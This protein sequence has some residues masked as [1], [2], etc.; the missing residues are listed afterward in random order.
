M[1]LF[2]LWTFVVALAVFAFT[3]TL[4]GLLKR[5]GDLTFNEWHHAYLGI[6]LFAVGLL[7]RM[8]AGHAGGWSLGTQIAG[9][10]L[11]FDDAEEHLVQLVTGQITYQSPAHALFYALFGALGIV[12][13]ANAVLDQTAQKL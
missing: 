11:A 12:K 8:L 7:L 2:L 13:K 1:C 3:I 4:G 10:F 9:A 5:G 6:V